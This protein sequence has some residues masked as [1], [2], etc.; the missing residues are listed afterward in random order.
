MH[1]RR[2]G[3]IFFLVASIVCFAL[4]LY[5]PILTSKMQVLGFYFNKKH[6]NIFDSV[7][8]FYSSGD[9]LIA[10][11]IFLFTFAFPIVKYVELSY[12]TIMGCPIKNKSAD[13]WMQNLDKWNMLDVFV[14]ALLL[15][16]FKMQ[17]G[18]M[19]M[20]MSVGSLFIALAVITRMITIILM[21]NG[22]DTRHDQEHADEEV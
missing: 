7:Q 18:L 8:L 22:D 6:I 12:R 9:Y 21:T 2:I 14:V 13:W 1:L 15:L 10:I 19:V 17:D 3:S 5:Y 20:N 11:I 4:G 16:N